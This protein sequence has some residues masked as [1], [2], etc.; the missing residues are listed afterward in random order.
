MA[1]RTKLALSFESSNLYRRRMQDPPNPEVLDSLEIQSLELLLQDLS[2]DAK[3][4][5]KN[6]PLPKIPMSNSH[7]ANVEKTR[8]EHESTPLV[9]S[10]LK[11]TNRNVGPTDLYGYCILIFLS[12][13][14][15]LCLKHKKVN[16]MF[17]LQ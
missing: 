1:D 2:I 4:K 13:S 12:S 16:I 3:V 5:M 6:R 8:A 17:L 14:T 11:H 7:E 15:L 9:F 10:Y